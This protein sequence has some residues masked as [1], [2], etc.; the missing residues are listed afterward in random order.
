MPDVQREFIFQP[1][2]ILL[3]NENEAEHFLA[4]CEL[5]SESL[6]KDSFSQFSRS[7]REKVREAMGAR[8]TL[9]S[10]RRTT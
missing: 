8:G 3:K 1:I 9:R 2:R 7:L 10:K 4:M 6:G 5:C